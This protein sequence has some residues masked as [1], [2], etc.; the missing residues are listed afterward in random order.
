MCWFEGGVTKSAGPPEPI[1]GM[2]LLPGSFSVHADGEPERLPVWLDAVRTGAAAGRLGRRRRRRPAVARDRARADRVVAAGGDGAALRRGRGRAGAPAGAAGAACRSRRRGTYSIPDDV[3]ELRAV[4]R[5][6]RVLDA[7]GCRRRTRRLGDPSS[8]RVP[9]YAL[10]RVR[11]RRRSTRRPSCARRRR[12][13]TA[14]RRAGPARP[15]G[16]VG[17]RRRAA[18]ALPGLRAGTGSSPRRPRRWAAGSG[19]R[20]R[21]ARSP[22]GSPTA[23]PARRTATAACWRASIRLVERPLRR[24]GGPARVRDS[25]AS[26]AARAWASAACLSAGRRAPGRARRALALAASAASRRWTISRACSARSA[27]AASARASR[28]SA[29]SRASACWTRSTKWTVSSR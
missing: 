8:T 28:T 25:A 9:R 27:S 13:P 21:T 17:L 19:R 6:R 10:R 7:Q 1:D 16:L 11:A 3:R 24:R 23:R 22:T 2:G 29:S 4:H 5:M 26:R 20:T 15:W 12:P 14:G 18:E